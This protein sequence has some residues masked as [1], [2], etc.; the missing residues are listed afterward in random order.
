MQ[1]VLIISQQKK[2]RPKTVLALDD[3]RKARHLASLAVVAG[4]AGGA[5][6]HRSTTSP[7]SGR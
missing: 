7:S 5:R 6:A 1:A 2:F 4:R 3:D